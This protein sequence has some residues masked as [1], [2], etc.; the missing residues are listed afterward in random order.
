MDTW[1]VIMPEDAP[2]AKKEAVRVD[3]LV[4]IPLFTSEQGWNGDIKAWAGERFG[5]LRLEGSFRLAYNASLFVREGLGYQLSFEHLVNTAPGSSLTFRPLAPRL[6]SKLYLIWNKYQ[7]LTPIAESF[8]DQ[9]IK[10]T[11][12]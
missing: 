2:L 12:V 9:T 11:T 10:S 4:G 5:E 6:E 3:D 1:D 8:V 7:S